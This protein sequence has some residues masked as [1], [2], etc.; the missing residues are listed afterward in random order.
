MPLAFERS[1][2]PRLGAVRD[3]HR[4]FTESF[5]S[6]V[7][8]RARCQVGSE[9]I[10]DRRRT[11]GSH[12]GQ[13]SLQ[14]LPATTGSV[15]VAVGCRRRRVRRGHRRGGVRLCGGG[16]R[17]GGRFGRRPGSASVSP[18][19][20][21][22][23]RS[24]PAPAL[25]CAAFRRASRR[26]PTHCE[27]GISPRLMRTPVISS[28]TPTLP[29]PPQSPTQAAAAAFGTGTNAS[30]ALNDRAR[31]NRN[32]S[33]QVAGRLRI[34]QRIRRGIA[35]KSL[36]RLV[37]IPEPTHAETQKRG[38]IVLS[39]AATRHSTSWGIA[40]R[41]SRRLSNTSRRSPATAT[42]IVESAIEPDFVDA[43]VAD[44]ERLERE[45][46]I[47]PAV[48]SL[49]GRAHDA[50]LQPADLRQALRAHPGARDVLP[51]VER[52]LDPGCLVS[53]LSSIA[54]GADEKPQP[55][56]ADDQLIPLPSRTCR[57]SATRCGR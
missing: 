42:A 7:T 39:R 3:R 57:S 11:G 12:Y 22:A 51:I 31:S 29:S 38:E 2:D 37:S 9:L 21:S 15:G 48:E 40:C 13:R 43:L 5:D 1:F 28:A 41:I 14:P 23:R 44:L 26:R 46:D 32:T 56:H 34:E 8:G 24:P 17:D 6:D 52:V 36:L 53:S 18:D 55:I 16:R 50:H 49:R 54:I 25:R 20:P 47:Q 10:G 33:P 19:S 4:G 30:A 27:S 45:L 35:G